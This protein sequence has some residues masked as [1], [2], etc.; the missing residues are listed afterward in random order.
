MQ[1]IN[2]K[3]ITYV[4]QVYL[5]KMGLRYFDKIIREC[6]PTGNLIAQE[7]QILVNN[8]PDGLRWQT[9]NDSFWALK[10]LL[11][12]LLYRWRI[13]YKARKRGNYRLNGRELSYS[14]TI[15]G[16]FSETYLHAR[17]GRGAALL[18]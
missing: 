6:F 16:L 15:C 8:G 3:S 18:P 13:G 9:P 7:E 4:A 12:A 1:R 2:V 5:R 14:D 17:R 11:Q 10:W